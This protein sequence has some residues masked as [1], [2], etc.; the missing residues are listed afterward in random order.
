MDQ[1]LIPFAVL[2]AL[3]AVSCSNEVVLEQNDDPKGNAI[4][5]STKVGHSSRA[6]ETTIKNLGDFDVIAKSVYNDGS[7]YNAYLIGSDAGGE[8]AE[9]DGNTSTWNLDHN[10]Y[11]PNSVRNV[12]FWAFTDQQV[13]DTDSTDSK[14]L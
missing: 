1:K 4:A 2:T 11:L 10:V 8:T 5:F 7:L 14:V 3:C 13:G 9:R 12:A 6:A